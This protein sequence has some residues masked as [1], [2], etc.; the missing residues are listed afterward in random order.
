MGSVLSVYSKFNPLNG[1][2]G[3]AEV[4]TPEQDQEPEEKKP[5]SDPSYTLVYQ[6]QETEILKKFKEEKEMKDKENQ[7]LRDMPSPS[8]FV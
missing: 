3:K 5:L 4:M 7:R 6:E 8:R 1:W 2:L